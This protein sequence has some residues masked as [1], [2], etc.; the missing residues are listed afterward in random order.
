MLAARQIGIGPFGRIAAA[1]DMYAVFYPL[2]P[3]RRAEEAESMNIEPPEHAI[4]ALVVLC[5]IALAI[6]WITE[7]FLDWLQ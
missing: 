2:N 4:R 3:R 5:G 6:I 1:K 7:I